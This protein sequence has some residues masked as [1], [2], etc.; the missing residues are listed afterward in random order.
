VTPPPIPQNPPIP[1]SLAT[2]SE[3]LDMNFDVG[4]MN[5]GVWNA[6]FNL[7]EILDLDFLFHCLLNVTSR[8]GHFP[9]HHTF[10]YLLHFHNP[11]HR[12]L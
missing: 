5:H 3:L 11:F 9:G 10:S 2:R 12:N 8:T 7:H 4:P 6:S 1:N